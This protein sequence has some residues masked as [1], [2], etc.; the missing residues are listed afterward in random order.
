MVGQTR[1]DVVITFAHALQAE[2]VLLHVL[3]PGAMDPRRVLPDEADARTFLETV[4]AQMGAA[5]VTASVVVRCGAAAP[6]IVAEAEM[7]G[8][9]LILLGAN[10]RPLLPTAVL[11]SV[12]NQV[13]RTAPCPVLLVRPDRAVAGHHQR[14]RS[15]G[16]DAART[17]ALTRRH[18]GL[19]T[20]ELGRVIGSVDRAHELGSDFRRRGLRRANSLDE[21]RFQR[22]LAATRAGAIL[23][24]IMVYKLGFGYYVE[25]GHHRVAAAR[26][27]GQTDIDADVTEFV[28]AAGEQ[29]AA[30]FAAR[31]EFEHATG[32]TDIGAAHPDSY[33]VL[34]RTILAYAQEEGIDEL[35]L[36]ARRWEGRV[37]RPLWED[38][39]AREAGAVFPGERTADI[40]ARLAVWRERSHSRSW[41]DALGGRGATRNAHT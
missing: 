37:F 36:A 35:S 11:G 30:L 27:N 20:I 32:L 5:G 9:S 33:A 38:I 1:I 7:L 41:G 29:A 6:I 16:E 18:L 17:G 24:P 10:I 34:L 21:Q 22:V 12:A 39:R 15:F 25:D 23:P 3:P 4:A 26:M 13:V 2:V 31:S 28:P 40:L 8:A 19:R 14:L